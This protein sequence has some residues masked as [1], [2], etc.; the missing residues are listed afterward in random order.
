VEVSTTKQYSLVHLDSTRRAYL[1]CVIWQ[2]GSTVYTATSLSRRERSLLSILCHHSF[3][4]SASQTRLAIE[5]PSATSNRKDFVM[6]S[7]AK[8]RREVTMT[9]HYKRV[10]VPCVVTTTSNIEAKSQNIKINHV[11]Q[12]GIARHFENFDYALFPIYSEVWALK[13]THC[14]Q[15]TG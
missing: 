7:R 14:R 13:A 8:H 15:R 9:E 11:L 4:K 12:R 6:N 3:G 5:L 10:R 2:H 1:G